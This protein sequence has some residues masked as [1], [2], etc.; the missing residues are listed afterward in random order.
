VP[1]TE[2]A[3]TLYSHPL[4]SYCWKVLMALYEADTPFRHAQVDGLPKAH[5]TLSGFWPIGKMPL[6]YDA[7]RDQ[8]VP[9]TTIIIEYLQQHYPGPVALIPHRAAAGLDARLWDR[10]FDCYVQTPM[11]KFVTD[12]LRQDRQRDPVGVAEASAMLDTAYAMLDQR[13]AT[14]AWATG[15]E[16]TMADCSA[17]PA[18]FYAEAVYPFSRSHRALAAYFSRLMDRPSARRTI[19][20]AQP[21]F[22]FFPFHD[23]LNPRFTSPDF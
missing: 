20:E 4:A 10:F 1:T 15:D 3:L 16:F 17:M 13:M 23:A 6:L 19:R 7:A 2:P 11:Q 5:P 8:A 9:E 14:R 22:H 12:R 18:L 21:Y